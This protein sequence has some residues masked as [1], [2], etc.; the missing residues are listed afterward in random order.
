[1]RLLRY[2]LLAAILS[3]PVPALSCSCIAQNLEQLYVGA[4]N[5]FTAVITDIEFVACPDNPA[6]YRCNNY[7]AGFETTKVFK[8]GTPFPTIKSY[9]GGAACGT[10]LAVGVE[11]L[12]FMDDGGNTGLCS[13]TRILTS[14][15]EY[16]VRDLQRLEDYISGRSPDLSGPWGSRRTDG[17]CTLMTDFLI[18]RGGERPYRGYIEVYY[19]GALATQPLHNTHLENEVG[20]QA[21]LLNMPVVEPVNEPP[22]EVQIAGETMA[23]IWKPDQDGWGG[24]YGLFGQEAGK[25]I[26]YLENPGEIRIRGLVPD[27]GGMDAEVRQTR[28]GTAI[29]D[30]LECKAQSD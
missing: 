6:G 18:D 20:F 23:L 15:Q 28:V 16:A 7:E 1:M 19:R 3:V 30:F 4:P 9:T 2:L 14:P 29:D 27:V 12:F 25:F 13:G 8:G 5:V 21:V 24:R 22:A 26:S 11:Y 10:S 17:M